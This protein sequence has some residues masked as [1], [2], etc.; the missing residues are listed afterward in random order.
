M[1]IYSDNLNELKLN[2]CKDD[3]SITF[4][5]TLTNPF[6]TDIINN[7]KFHF[8]EGNLFKS[9]DPIFTEPKYI[10]EDG[11]VSSMSLQERRNKYYFSY[12][13]IFKTYDQGNRELVTNGVSYDNLEEDSYL[14]CSSKHLSDF[15]LNYEYNPEPNIIL[16]R[17]YFLK[18]FKLFTNS[19]NL[20]GNYGFYSIILVI[21]LYFFNFIVVKI[22][23]II[24]KKSLGNKNYLVIEEFLMDY[25]YPYGNIEGDFFVNKENMNKIYNKNLN[26][27]KE[28][29]KIKE[30]NLMKLKENKNIETETNLVRE[31]KINQN[32]RKNAYLNEN[33]L[34]NYGDIKN[35]KLYEQYYQE[36]NA[37]GYNTDELEEEIEKKDEKIPKNKGRNKKN[38]KEITSVN[39]KGE[40]KNEEKT[41]EIKKNKKR[42]RNNFVS[43]EDK[44]SNDEIEEEINEAK[45]FNKRNKVNINHLIHSLQISNENLRVRILSKMKV[46]VCK[47]FC[48][49][50]KNRIILLNTF[51]GNY[52]YSASIKAL[53]F[54]LYLEILLFV[55]TFIFITLEDESNFTDY[56]KN[57]IGDFLW[58][59]LLPLILV[60]VY[61]YSTRYFY[62]ID[63][64]KVRTLLYEF[65]TSR[66]SFDKHYF[67]LL[68]KV[69]NMMIVETILFFL[70]AALTYIFVFGLFA[71]YPSQGKTMFVSLI[72]GIA[73]DLLFNFLLELLI[74]VLYICRKNHIIVVVIDYANRLLSYKM[75]SP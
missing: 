26:L 21:A 60:K 25:V 35:K 44:N 36:I 12:L 49:N 11:S 37:D 6:L 13:L 47:F 38:K 45:D 68:K 71:V 55:N 28:K 15:I 30:L 32:L 39:S 20:N 62:N 65:K 48:V 9:D 8:K 51:T 40:L 59:C 24:K 27:K 19:K 22:I 7:N 57:N 73:I 31:K 56:I 50:L 63:N 64:G 75:L 17:F 74:A 4:Y 29:E 53:C 58:R 54:P 14:R 41:I 69:R 43:K 33:N 52:T 70:M 10:L 23:L 66:K 5:L 46:N 3:S 18:H 67:N 16:G 2:E 1:K 42:K 34:M 61:F 72:C